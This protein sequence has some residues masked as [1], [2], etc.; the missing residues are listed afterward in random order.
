MKTA[1]QHKETTYTGIAATRLERTHAT[2]K[3]TYGFT[4]E[5]LFWLRV[6]VGRRFAHEF[7]RTL[8]SGREEVYENL[9][10][11]PDWNYWN[12]WNLQWLYDDAAL[13]DAG[14]MTK[15]APYRQLKEAMIGAEILIK[16]LYWTI[17]QYT[18]LC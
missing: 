17:K 6:D 5:D 2:V 3:D 18:E 4:E 11:N 16:D 10:K 7:T 12:W 1:Q 8:V 9:T 13:I 14:C 15:D